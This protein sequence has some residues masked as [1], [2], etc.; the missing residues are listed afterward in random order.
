MLRVLWVATKAPHPAIDGGRL[1][2]ATTLDA[3]VAAGAIVTLVAPSIGRATAAGAEGMRTYL[4]DVAPRAWWAAGLA[5]LRSGRPI[6]VERH[7]HAAVAARVADLIQRERFDLVH[8]E[9]PQALAGARPAREAGLPCVLRAQNVESTLWHRLRRSGWTRPL[10]QA[11]ARRMRRFEASALATADV[12]IALSGLDAMQLAALDPSARV[13][14]VPPPAV[15]HL[16]GPAGPALAGDPAFVWIGSAGWSPNAEAGAWLMTE[17][18][19]AIGARLPDARLHVFGRL[20]GP[21]ART[22]TAG[23]GTVG[24]VIVHEAPRDSSVAFAPDSILLLPLRTPAGVRMRLLE[25]W[26]RGVPVIASPAAVEGLETE[27]DEDVLIAS[28]ARAFAACAARLA[29]DPEQRARLIRGGRATLARRHDPALIARA[30][31]DA[32]REAID[33]HQHADGHHT[34]MRANAS[35]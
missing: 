14:V 7:T 19:P 9:Q 13:I 21:G 31:L 4:V 10:F 11:E 25:A 32:Y 28:D 2:M 23:P 16:S 3:L 35:R 17:I 24:N 27:H 5:S 20:S 18:W 34:S 33:R 22:G 26:G 1:V 12:T 30:T 8:V 6:S 15:A 29:A